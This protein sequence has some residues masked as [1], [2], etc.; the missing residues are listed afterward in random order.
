MHVFKYSRHLQDGLAP[1][2]TVVAGIGVI[3]GDTYRAKAYTA[4]DGRHTGKIAVEGNTP[5][6]V[7]ILSVDNT[8]MVPS[9]LKKYFSIDERR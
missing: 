4:H 6:E 8:R 7:N 1:H 5:A 3:G 9:H 2:T